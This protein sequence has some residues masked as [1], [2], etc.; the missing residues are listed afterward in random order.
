MVLPL[1]GS[2]KKSV[3]EPRPAPSANMAKI[4]YNAEARQ[5][6]FSIY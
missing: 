4:I 5:L 3:F 6:C 2:H 1:S